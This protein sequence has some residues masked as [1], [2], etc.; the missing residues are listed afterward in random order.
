M[1]A[2]IS[3][4]NSGVPCSKPEDIKFGTQFSDHMFVMDYTPSNGWHDARIIPYGP[5]SIEPS[6]M[7]FHYGQEMFEGLKAYAT[8]QGVALFRPEENIKRFNRSCDRMCMPKVDVDF[9]VGAIKKLVEIDKKWVPSWKDTSLYIRPFI[10]ATDSAI[11]LRP[12][13][14]FKFIVICT[15][16][17]PFY[18]DGL[19]PVRI[20]V[21][22][23]YVRAVKGGLG[24]TK[25]GANYA[26]SMRAQEI[27][28]DRGFEQVLWLDGIEHKYIEEVGSMNVFFVIGKEIITP[29]LSGS[30]LAGITRM[31]V[32]ELMRKRGYEVVERKISIEELVE[33]YNSGLLKEAFGTGTAAVISPMGVLRYKDCDMVLNNGETGETTRAVYDGLVGIQSGGLEDEFGWMTFV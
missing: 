31:S 9:V 20:Y 24:F 29:E 11:G 6:A 32:I 3:N 27:A 5:L 12:S 21:E 17:R 2:I 7:V 14:T 22:E 16:A 19:K 4:K 25:A 18:S 13:D 28:H 15:P 8:V 23:E 30:I 10:I 1:I 26:A 33:F